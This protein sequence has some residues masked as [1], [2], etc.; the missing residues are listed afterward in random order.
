MDGMGPLTAEQI[1]AGAKVL[2]ACRTDEPSLV[3]GGMAELRASSPS[4]ECRAMVRDLGKC[5]PQCGRRRASRII[6]IHN[7]HGYLVH[8]FLSPISNTRND[9]YGGDFEGR[10]RFPLDDRRSRPRRR[11]EGNAAVPPRLRRRW[12]RWRPAVSTT[13]LPDAIALRQRGIDLVDCS[14][15]GLKGPATVART[16]KR[17]WK[18][19]QVPFA[20]R[21]KKEA[22]RHV[23]MAV[24]LILDPHHAEDILQQGQADLIAVGRQS[25]YNPNIAHHWAARSRHQ[26]VA[27]RSGRRNM[28]GGWRSGFRTME[29]FATPTGVVTRRS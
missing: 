1:T 3:R 18:G 10:T 26:H 9:A 2:A 4:D 19:F 24:G 29:G 8:Q 23:P 27:S 28:A 6:E 11:A 13:P 15:G 20:E 5:R 25:Q 16:Y 21:V 12:H 7:A 17:T 22:E 14:S